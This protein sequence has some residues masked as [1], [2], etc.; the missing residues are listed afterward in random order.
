MTAPDLKCRVLQLV[1]GAQ[2][3]RPVGNLTNRED[4]SHVASTRIRNCGRTVNTD[5]GCYAPLKFDKSGVPEP[6]YLFLQLVSGTWIHGPD[7]NIMKREVP[8]HVVPTRMKSCRRT[9]NSDIGCYTPLKFDKSGVTD[10]K[11]L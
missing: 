11:F 6:K 4:A 7:S 1:S 3:H 10:C 9:V 8:S 2:I 5:I